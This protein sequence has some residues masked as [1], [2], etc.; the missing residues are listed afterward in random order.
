MKAVAKIKVQTHE[1]GVELPAYL[2]EPHGDGPF[3]GVLVVHELNGLDLNAR[4]KVE[5]FASAGYVALAPDLFSAAGRFCMIRTLAAS[6]RGRGSAFDYLRSVRSWL[7]DRDDVDPRNIG[8]AGFCMGGGFAVFLAADPEVKAAA[9]FYGWVPRKT[10]KLGPLC[11]V[12]GGWGK[13]DVVFRESA[14][15]LEKHLG[16]VGSPSD[17]ESYEDVGHGFMNVEGDPPWYSTGWPIYVGYDGAAADDGWDRVL[18]FFETHL[19]APPLH[20]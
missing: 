9:P 5:R 7:A 16:E 14:V 17:I 1:P 20:E 19:K 18:A 15:R 4:E 12:V 3:P 6:F 13:K 10:S 2:G 8:V 11:P